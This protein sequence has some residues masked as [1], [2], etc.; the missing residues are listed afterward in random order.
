VKTNTKTTRSKKKA[1]ASYLE[2][3]PHRA[4]VNPQRLVQHPVERGAVITELFP[5][6]LLLLGVGEVGG[7]RVDALLA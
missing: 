3:T 5:Q 7:G 2:N 4:T 6:L 1:T